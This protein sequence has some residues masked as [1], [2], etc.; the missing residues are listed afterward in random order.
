VGLPAFVLLVVALGALIPFLPALRASFLADDFP[1]VR[2]FLA[3]RQTWLQFAVGA[4]T[5]MRGIPL[6]F[7]RPL[8]YIMLYTETCVWGTWAFGSHAVSLAL[9][10]VNTLLVVA[11]LHRLLQH[12]ARRRLSALRHESESP[13]GA[14]NARSMLGPSA[15]PLMASVAAAL[16]FAIHPRRVEAV[17]WLSCRPDLLCATFALVAAFAYVRAAESGDWRWDLLSWAS[18]C[19]AVM[20]KEAALL[21]PLCFPFFDWLTARAGGARGTIRP[22]RRLLPF[23]IS[24]VLYPILRRAVIGEWIG[25]YGWSALRPS[26]STLTSVPKFI[27]YGLLPPLEWSNRWLPADAVFRLAAVFIGLLVGFVLVLAFRLRGDRSVWAAAAWLVACSLP[28]SSLRLSLGTTFNDRFLY[29]PS[30]AAALFIAAA[31]VRVRARWLA[32]LVLLELVLGVQ[33]WLVT[34][35]WRVASDLTNRIVGQVAERLHAAGGGTPVYL[36]SLPDSYRGAYMLRSGIRD[37]LEI[38]GAE[39]GSRLVELSHYFLE[40][41]DVAPLSARL[42]GNLVVALDAR[43]GQPEILPSGVRDVPVLASGTRR[44][45]FGRLDHVEFRLPAPGPVWLVTPAAIEVV[46]R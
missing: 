27:A 26:L 19:G 32:A 41:P 25:G 3:S 2:A 28:A 31:L 10:V 33:T 6:N 42:T 22:A 21:L 39:G 38:R 13:S 7:Y 30:V 34:D 23:I 46:G 14:V 9:H 44:D 37:A 29:L 12:D 1:V 24:I 4:L 35:R 11:L 15:T 5:A 17:A 40:T 18:W 36:A 45:R 16:F 20:S 43:S 8:P